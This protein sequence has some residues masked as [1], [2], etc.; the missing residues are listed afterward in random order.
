MRFEDE[1]VLNHSVLQSAF[2]CFLS[3]RLKQE[4]QTALFTQT[5]N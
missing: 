3:K 1:L 2:K 5:S 4:F